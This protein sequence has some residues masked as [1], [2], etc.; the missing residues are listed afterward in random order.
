[1]ILYYA[2]DTDNTK[3]METHSM[4]IKVFRDEGRKY[5]NVEIPY[6]EKYSRV[7]EIH[8]RTVGQDG[9]VA[10]FADIV[11]DRDI[12]KTRKLRFHAKVLTLPNVQPGTVIEYSYRLHFKE[13]IPDPFKNP[14]QYIFTY[15]ITYPA[16]EWEIQR[17][18][19]VSRG[20]FTLLPTKGAYV[21]GFTIGLRTNPELQRLG[22]GRLFVEVKDIPPFEEEEYAPPEASTRGKLYLYYAAGFYGSDDYWLSFARQVAKD[23]D[24]FIGKSNAVERE[25]ARLSTLGGTR[26]EK[27][28]RLYERVQQTRAMSYETEKTEKERSR[29]NLKNNKDAE[30]V[31]ERGYGYSNE[32]NLLFIALA[33]AAGFAADPVLVTSR[34]KAFFQHEY[35]YWGQLDTMLVEVELDNHPLYL[36]PGTRFCPYGLLPWHEAAAGGVAL[37]HGIAELITTSPSNS[38]DAV[39]S[40]TAQLKLS[41]EGTLSGKVQMSYSGQ[42]ALVWR[43]WSLNE[44][45]GKRREEEEEGLK[46]KLSHGATVKLVT[47]NGWEKT[48]G[49]LKMEFEIEVPDYATKAG[50]RLVLPVGVFHAGETNP[51]SPARRTHPVYFDYPFETSEDVTIELPDGMRVEEFPAEKK[52]ENGLFFQL[53]VKPEA[54]SLRILRARKMPGIG[55]AVTQYPAIRA[56]YASV[57][58]ADSQQVTISPPAKTETK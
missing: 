41:S 46:R 23:Y 20:R 57:L 43:T 36:D 14:Q 30:Q 11:Y 8:A 28:K 32:I 35:P 44:A 54:T 49:P 56:F 4:R 48:E 55:F 27:L 26:E 9:K 50:R 40:T 39:T 6:L 25:A 34:S 29:E 18:L 16:A 3:S 12:V 38:A 5:A 45:A 53:S 31:L 10:E 21:K 7:E 51:L 58:A 19:Y 2:V 15:G 1:M 42:E 24:K 13:N 33:R 22:D 47:E 37:N 52:I 17:D